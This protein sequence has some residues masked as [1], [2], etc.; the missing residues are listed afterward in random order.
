MSDAAHIRQFLSIFSPYYICEE[1]DV[2]KSSG[3]LP[4]DLYVDLPV[5]TANALLRSFS[6]EVSLRG[7]GVCVQRGLSWWGGAP[8]TLNKPA[9]HEV[10]WETGSGVQ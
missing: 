5:H 7:K 10:V 9:A 3:N 8:S 1:Q 4:V 6:Q 2:F